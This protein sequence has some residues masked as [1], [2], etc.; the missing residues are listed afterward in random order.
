MALSTSS[1]PSRVTATLLL[2]GLLCIAAHD[3]DL[4]GLD[5]TLIVE[6]EV[7][8]LDEE[9]PDFVAEAVG[10][11]MTLDGWSSASPIPPDIGPPIP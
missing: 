11:Q 6:L 9:R 7:D 1:W 10:I 2:S 3:L 4:L 8:I 5:I